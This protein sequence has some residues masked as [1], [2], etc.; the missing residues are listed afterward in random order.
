MSYYPLNKINF[1]QKFIFSR[2]KIETHID[3]RN[4]NGYIFF[5]ISKLSVVSLST[6][7]FHFLGFFLAFLHVFFLVRDTQ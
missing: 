5:E 1:D 4:C 2:E 7:H 6:Q 3:V